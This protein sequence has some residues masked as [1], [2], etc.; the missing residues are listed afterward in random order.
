[1]NQN[2]KEI[3]LLKLEMKYN[4]GGDI[5]VPVRL[6]FDNCFLFPPEFNKINFANLK[7]ERNPNILTSSL[8]L[9]HRAFKPIGLK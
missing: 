4:R 2:S 6:E 8:Q 7:T 1:M 9:E 3:I 5:F